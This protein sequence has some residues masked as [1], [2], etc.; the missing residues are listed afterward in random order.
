[1]QE[2]SLHYLFAHLDTLGVTLRHPAA[3]L[4]LL[5]LPA[6]I[7]FGQGARQAATTLRMAAFVTVT[8]AL[9]GLALTARLPSDRLS[10]VAAVDVS[11]SIDE[12]AR[13]WDVRYL[14]EL[15]G[16]LAP[17]DEMAVVAFAQGAMVVQ[18]PGRP[19][20]IEGLPRTL[21]SSATDIARGLDASLSLFDPDSEHRLVLL[22]DGLE[23]RGNSRS[24]IARA[25]RAK[26]SI[27]AAV[28][29]HGVHRDV[30][31]ER[32]IVSPVVN[33]GAVFP[34]RV[35][36]RNY[37][38]PGP[39]RLTL[40][41]DG[42]ALGSETVDLT[43][44]LNAIEIPYRMSGSGSHLLRAELQAPGDDIPADNERD[45]TVMVVGKTR[46]LLITPETHSVLAAA[47][48]RKDIDA[49]VRS[50]A[51]FPHQVEDLL[52]YNC[53]ILEDVVAK[54]LD[55]KCLQSLE[56]YVRNFGG[57]LILLGSDRT[58]GDGG[59]KHTALETLLPVTL[60]PRR[61]QHTEREPLAL[62]V[63][64]DR[65]NSMGYNSRI[66]NLRDGEKLRYARQAALAV[67]RQ[68]KDH[69]LVGVI[70][71]DSQPFVLSPLRPL[72]ENRRILEA[73]IPRLAEGGGTDFYDALET[74]R[75]Q[76]V[77][78]GVST[79][80]IILLTDGDTNRGASDHYPLIAALRQAGISVTTIRIGDDTVNLTLLHDI[81]SKTGGQFYHV[82]NVETLPELMLRDTTERLVQVPGGNQHFRA[83][84]GVPSPILQGIAQK[85]MPPLRGYAYARLRPGAEAPLYV[86]TRDR[87]DPLLADWQY[88][89]GRVV[90]FTAGLSDDAETWVGW[91]RF[92]KLW[93]QVVRWSVRDETPRDYALEVHRSEGITQLVVRSFDAIGEGVLLAR[94]RVSDDSTLDV[95][96]VPTAPRQFSGRLPNLPGGRYA[97]TIVKR[98][99]DRVVS[100]RTALIVVPEGNEPARE[101]RYAP[102]PDMTLL[103]QLSK[104]TGGKVNPP[105]R[106]L[107]ARKPGARQLT[108][109]LDP[110]LLPLAMLLFLADVAIRRLTAPPVH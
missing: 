58:Y 84:L 50:P 25:R 26:V 4:L 45:A 14:N 23:T 55:P 33:E 71:F 83:Q 8:L 88:G 53:V 99:S 86:L 68:L 54:G 78:S 106:E 82:E 87:K 5:L 94:L 57:G 24:E 101:E 70:A 66:R 105:I 109:P 77:E 100:Q 110:L 92:G 61:P 7:R 12:Q 10:V 9:A 27:Y 81:S 22:T 64:I 107:V 15:A 35:I 60:E 47:L 34:L 2:P 6:F 17:G 46:V 89:L 91:P 13:Q 96:L 75:T 76:L 93:S 108:H 80:H 67:I 41:A 85:E 29:P 48:A 95:P 65:S 40:F 63:L 56:R 1:M 21:A 3:L 37:A 19:S 97:L 38:R 11:D 36:A 51:R 69:D 73:T 103:A 74:A 28:P 59:F 79:K 44:G 30:A 90:A 52:G 18:P 43:T 49:D 39:A 104:A 72:R 42:Q 98:S 102:T 62:F 20:T 16:A 32:L 31:L